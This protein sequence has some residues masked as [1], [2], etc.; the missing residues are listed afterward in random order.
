MTT[1]SL[2]NWHKVT[3]KE[4]SKYLKK[5]SLKV[6]FPWTP[7]GLHRRWLVSPKKLS[8]RSS[9]STKVLGS[10]TL[11]KMPEFF[12]EINIEAER[13][14]GR[15]RVREK[16]ETTKFLLWGLRQRETEV[17]QTICIYYSSIIKSSYFAPIRTKLQSRV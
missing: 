12:K 9:Y 10:L 1:S 4:V 6:L 2:Q 16:R 15:E 7:P 17:V 3:S 11:T 14:R 5:F 8:L 13:E